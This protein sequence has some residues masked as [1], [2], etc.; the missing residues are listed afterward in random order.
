[1]KKKVDQIDINNMNSK[2]AYKI[3]DLYIKENEK[4]YIDKK[5]GW[6]WDKDKNVVGVVDKINK[7]Y[8]FDEIKL[9]DI[10]LEDLIF[11]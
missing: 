1:M 6:I 8:F 2:L 11:V 4:F 10:I 9:D 5:M 7:L 3:F